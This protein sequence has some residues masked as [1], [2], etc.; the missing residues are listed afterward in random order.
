MTGPV[1]RI[2][3]TLLWSWQWQRVWSTNPNDTKV[4]EFRLLYQH[5]F[6]YQS[7]IKSQSWNRW[8]NGP[9]REAPAGRKMLKR[10]RAKPGSISASGDVVKRFEFGVM[11][12]SWNVLYLDLQFR[13]EELAVMMTVDMACKLL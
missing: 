11:N 8:I 7:A 6:D 13:A 3:N 5:A 2:R 10:G 9:F 12:R 4:I 1:E